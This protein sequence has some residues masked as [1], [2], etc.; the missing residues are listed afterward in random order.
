VTRNR[1]ASSIRSTS[2]RWTRGSVAEAASTA[3][4]KSLNRASL[5]TLPARMILE[6]VRHALLAWLDQRS[7]SPARFT[8]NSARATMRDPLDSRGTVPCLYNFSLMIAYIYIYIYTS[9]ACSNCLVKAVETASPASPFPF[10]GVDYWHRV[11]SA[12]I[13]R[14]VIRASST[15]RNIR[16]PCLARDTG[17]FH[18]GLALWRDT[19]GG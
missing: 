2:I 8:M 7:V 1:H 19:R 4:V 15:N 10:R 16:A 18:P 17:H 9:R 3:A 5:L 12:M 14:L 11:N 13:T 6:V